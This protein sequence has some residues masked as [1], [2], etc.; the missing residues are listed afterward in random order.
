MISATLERKRPSSQSAFYCRDVAKRPRF[1]LEPRSIDLKDLQEQFLVALCGGGGPTMG[2]RIAEFLWSGGA[3]FKDRS[4]KDFK[5]LATLLSTS[6]SVQLAV[7][8]GIKEQRAF[9]LAN[10]WTARSFQ[11]LC[12]YAQRWCPTAWARSR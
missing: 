11:A 2:G 1:R 10:A 7:V 4:E 8:V 6:H 5:D 12:D 3:G 9:S